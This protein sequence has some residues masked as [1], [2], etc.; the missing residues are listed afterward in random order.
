MC[1]ISEFI[2]VLLFIAAVFYSVFTLNLPFNV[3][4]LGSNLNFPTIKCRIISYCIYE[5]PWMHLVSICGQTHRS[6]SS[7]HDSKRLSAFFLT[8]WLL[9]Y[10]YLSAKCDHMEVS[11]LF[12]HFDRL[13]HL[14]MSGDDSMRCF[15]L[16]SSVTFCWLRS[17]YYKYRF[18]IGNATTYWCSTRRSSKGHYLKFPS[19]SS[20]EEVFTSFNW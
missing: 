11:C 16:Q 4:A 7:I 1:V 18:T 10:K 15:I 19:C 3:T 5:V 17:G 9:L 2:L 20:V 14:Y 12:L 8:T 13:C 6:S